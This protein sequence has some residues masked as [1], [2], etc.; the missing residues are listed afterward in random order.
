MTAVPAGTLAPESPARSSDRPESV[1]PSVI[2]VLAMSALLLRLA[3][4]LLIANPD[5]PGAMEHTS[6][7]KGLLLGEG[8]SFNE[9][10]G[11]T[12]RG[13][14]E[15]SSVQSPPYPLFLAGLFKIFGVDSSA[16]YTAA[17]IVNAVFAALTVPALY[18]LT[19]RLAPD[20]RWGHV[21]GVLAAGLFAIWPTQVFA[22][23]Q[24][25]A[26]VAITFGFVAIA[27]LWLESLETGRIL[28][29]IAYGV[30]GCFAALTEPVLLPPMALSGVWVLL[31]PRLPKPLRLR[32]GAILLA[33][34]LAIIGPWTWRNYRVHDTFMPIKSTFWVNVWK[35]NN[36]TDPGHSGTDR[37]ELT[38]ERLAQVQAT[39][40]DELRQ[41]DLLTPEQRIALDGKPAV[42]REEL[43]GQWA[44]SW[45]SENP[46]MYAAVSGK[47]LAKT[48]WWDWD[49]PGGYKFFYLYPT[50]RAVLL[51][52]TLVGGFVAWRRGWHF[53]HVMLL[54]GLAVLT[55][56]LTVTAAR[57]GLPMEPFQFVLLALAGVAIFGRRRVEQ[58]RPP[59]VASFLGKR[60][61]NDGE[62]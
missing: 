18:L 10:A 42:Q 17:W 48:L 43:F 41:Y 7:A 5:A 35:G 25:Q 29:W 44:K 50:T 16:A 57:F 39:G 26:V 28:P 23:T 31:T 52:A 1:L 58:V 61:I 4:I 22:V 15:P 36:A 21:V 46:S 60:A 34:A 12:E 32:N 51:L 55:Y 6:L 13:L 9:S 8:F 53:S 3:A 27:W 56:T 37:P 33:L 11:Y 30:I 24:A 2:V 20:Q 19:R 14:Y 62:A 49:H 47:R 38:A 54:S 45:I 59:I 40:R